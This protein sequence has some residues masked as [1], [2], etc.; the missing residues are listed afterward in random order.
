MVDTLA[1]KVELWKEA[2]L[3]MK[4]HREEGNPRAFFA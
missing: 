1:P 3:T 2:E 4:E